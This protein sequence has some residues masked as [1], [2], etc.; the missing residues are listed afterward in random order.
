MKATHPQLMGAGPSH[1]QPISA[2]A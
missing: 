2:D 1:V